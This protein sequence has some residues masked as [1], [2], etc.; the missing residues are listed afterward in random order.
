MRNARTHSQYNTRRCGLSE[1]V[2]TI[3][4]RTHQFITFLFHSH[5]CIK[6]MNANKWRLTQVGRSAVSIF[7]PKQINVLVMYYISWCTISYNNFSRLTK[8][9]ISLLSFALT[10]LAFQ[11]ISFCIHCSDSFSSDF[12]ISIE[13]WID[14]ELIW[15]LF[16]FHHFVTLRKWFSNISRSSVI[17]AHGVNYIIAIVTL[18]QKCQTTVNYGLS[19]NASVFRK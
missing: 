3:I 9:K 2:S 8:L 17:L 5:S 6:R 4:H 7:L 14:L 1:C 15:L 10:H 18:E 16:F 19:R 12:M 11:S 13:H